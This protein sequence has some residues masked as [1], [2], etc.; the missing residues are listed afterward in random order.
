MEEKLIHYNP[1]R[2]VNKHLKLYLESKLQKEVV[3]AT[4][5]KAYGKI[6]Q[7]Y[8]D[9]SKKFSDWPVFSCAMVD[10][11]ID[12][13]QINPVM[14]R[15]P[16]G[17]SGT[18]FD[19]PEVN[20]THRVNTHWIPMTFSFQ[21]DIWADTRNRMESYLNILIMIMSYYRP[22]TIYFQEGQ[23]L[24]STG[25]IVLEGI[26]ETSDLDPGEEIVQFRHTLTFNV[27]TQ[28]P[29]KADMVPLIYEKMARVQ[30]DNEWVDPDST[31]V[32]W[33]DATSGSSL[34]KWTLPC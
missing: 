26:S 7:A 28:I 10:K 3:F 33:A 6:V 29:V 12:R 13:E 30:I 23:Y 16:G 8:S 24:S 11:R 20:P 22:F 21:M 25:I 15:L 27:L 31:D 5:Q 32:V 18:S 4:P 9:K 14:A 19:T 17:F 34:I 1:F 2:S